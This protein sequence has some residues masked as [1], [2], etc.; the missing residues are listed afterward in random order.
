MLKLARSRK[1]LHPAELFPPCHAVGTNGV[2]IEAVNTPDL[3]T[4]AEMPRHQM[5]RVAS[6]GHRPSKVKGARSVV[7]VRSGPR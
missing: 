1:D 2:P 4:F 6:T 7:C 5:S 3:D